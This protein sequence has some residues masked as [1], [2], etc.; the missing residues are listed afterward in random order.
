[1]FML[2]KGLRCGN[3]LG[4]YVPPPLLASVLAPHWDQNHILS[5]NLRLTLLS[6][7]L[8]DQRENINIQFRARAR[9]SLAL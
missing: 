8:G 7:R 1:V 9:V 6:L 3:A 2:G 4:K 5:V